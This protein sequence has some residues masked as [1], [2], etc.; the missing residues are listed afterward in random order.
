M[1][2]VMVRVQRDTKGCRIIFC[3]AHGVNQMTREAT[4][5]H[6]HVYSASTADRV[7]P[8]ELM[9]PE[10]KDCVTSILSCPPLEA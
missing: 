8:L 7:S 3:E 1:F 5:P 6:L 4:M 9:F 2:L 10:G